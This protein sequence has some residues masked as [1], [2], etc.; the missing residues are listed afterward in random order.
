MTIDAPATRADLAEAVATPVADT[1]RWRIFLYLGVLLLLLGFASPGGGLIGLPISFFLKN[2]L[3]LKAHELATFQLISHIPV[4]FSFAFGFARDRF[5]P[6]GMRDRGFMILFGAIAAGLY[7]FFAFVHPTYATLMVAVLL[8]YITFL[9]LLS[10]QRGLT[11]TIGQQHVMSGQVSAAWNIFE[12]LPGD[13]R[14]PRR[15]SAERPH[16]G[17]GRRSGGAPALSG[18][19]PDRRYTRPLWADEAGERVWPPP[20]RAPHQRPP[21][22]RL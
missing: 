21:M 14:P 10:A 5:N 20:L 6:F 2:K 15:G 18:R 13:R 8:L 17:P 12:G 1:T 11:A 22:G 9:F 16:G 7:V 19:R 4:Y 3:H